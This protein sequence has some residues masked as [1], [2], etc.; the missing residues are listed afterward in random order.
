MKKSTPVRQLVLRTL[1]RSST[2][3]ILDFGHFRMSCALGRS[4]ISAQKREGDGATPLG[5]YRLEKVYYRPDR[6]ARPRTGLPLV[7]LSHADGWCDAPG[8]RNYNRLV[9]LPYA[10]SAEEMWRKDHLYDL[11]IVLN[12]NRRPRVQGAGSA[13]F[14]HFAREGYRPTEGCVALKGR[15][16]LKVL[17]HAHYGHSLRTRR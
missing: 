3:G 13:I 6:M 4:G 16:I 2:R 9:R 14:M 10:A 11:I 15:D 5:V 1:S 8:D 12:Y 17:A 7:A